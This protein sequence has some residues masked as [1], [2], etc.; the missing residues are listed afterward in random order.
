M[1]DVGARQDDDGGALPRHTPMR[2][3]S[4]RRRRG[5]RPFRD[6]AAP[7]AR[8]RLSPRIRAARSRARF[9][10]EPAHDVEGECRGIE[11]AGEAVRQR[12]RTS[13]VTMRPAA[14]PCE[15]GGRLDFDADDPPRIEMALA[16]DRDAADQAPSADRN[17]DCIPRPVGSSSISRPIVPA[18]AITSGCEYGEMNSASPSR[19]APW[20]RARLRCA[21]PRR[22]SRGTSSAR[23]LCADGVD[24]GAGR[25]PGRR[26]SAQSSGPGGVGERAAVVAGRGGHEWG[27]LSRP[28]GLPRASTS[29]RTALN[30]PRIL[31]ENVGWRVSSFRKTRAG[32]GREPR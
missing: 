21:I 17:D 6:D 4:P 27:R 13:I 25:R 26:P 32:R 15:W 10:H 5:A 2:R 12:G 8:F 3:R 20:R 7:R 16:G 23:R 30:A 22:R 18:P 11:I 28:V 29:P 24:L 9:G 19:H 1:I 14:S 31:Y